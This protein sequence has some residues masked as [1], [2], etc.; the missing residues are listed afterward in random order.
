MILTHFGASIYLKKSE[1]KK[2]EKVARK[3]FKNTLAA[4]DELKITI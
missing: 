2:A 1:R 4:F 3:I